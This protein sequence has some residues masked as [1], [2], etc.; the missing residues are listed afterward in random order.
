MISDKYLGV[1]EGMAAQPQPRSPGTY[2]VTLRLTPGNT[3][4]IVGVICYRF[5]D[6]KPGGQKKSGQTGVATL[7]LAKVTCAYIVVTEDEWLIQ[8]DGVVS[9]GAITLTMDPR[10]PSIRYEY[11]QQ[12][13]QNGPNGDG[14]LRRRG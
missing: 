2:N 3:G 1:W 5:I 13:G 9:T 12:P 14:E 4:D 7:K 11:G 10:V 8:D 6:L